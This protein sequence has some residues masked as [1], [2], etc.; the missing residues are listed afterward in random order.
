MSSQFDFGSAARARAS[1]LSAVL[2][3]ALASSAH[4]ANYGTDLN[5]TM[6]PAAGGMGGVG[7]ARPQDTSA[8][9]F[10]NPATLGQF[11]DATRFS[12]GATFYKPD[13]RDTHDGS[14]TG[15]P[16]S[17][18]SDASDYLLPNLSIVQPLGDRF[19]LGLGI[20]PIAGIG[21]DFRSVPGS[22][23]PLAE[24]IVWGANAGLAYQIDD[25]WSVGGTV[26]LGN[27]YFQAGLV[28]NGASV[29][30]YGVRAT[31]G[32]TYETGGTTFGA[33]YRSPLS[34]EYENA[35]K[36][37]ATGFHDLTVEQPQEVAF[38]IA[39]A[40]LMNGN[41]L[42]EADVTWKNWEQADF[43]RDIYEDQTIFALG[44]Q[45]TRGKLSWRVG[46]SYA[47][48][49]IKDNV[50]SNVG[51]ATSLLAGGATVQL[52][53]V[54]V[55]YLQATNAEVIWKH[56]ITAGLGYKLNDNFR[57]DVHAAAALEEEER[58]GGT[59]VEASA[60]QV[61]AGLTWAFN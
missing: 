55:R 19:T 15:T 34:I 41:L 22:L 57:I 2:M 24:L 14:A 20:T 12:F 8:S 6:M 56:Q 7:I 46:Y 11:G 50:G 17:A 47:D 39:N 26:T 36:F 21:S 43:Y 13:V 16:W 3:G 23:S 52:N 44:A 30:S 53:P 59:N 42:I 4:A 32:T 25:N 35:T 28:E 38:G 54:L 9:V 29:H 31:L 51:E 5:L 18:D 48:S 61:G 1:A 27:G 33:Y 37:S 10:G 60:W 45:L 58:I 49:P 40:S